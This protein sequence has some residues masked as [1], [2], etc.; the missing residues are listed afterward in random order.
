MSFF[1]DLL[2]FES[3]SSSTQAQPSNPLPSG[4]ANPGINACWLAS[5]LQMIANTPTLAASV[6]RSEHKATGAFIQRLRTQQNTT[7]GDIVSV[8]Q[9][10]SKATSL[11]EDNGNQQD[12]A[13]AL[14]AIL[15]M[16]GIRVQATVVR[17]TQPLDPSSERSI[18]IRVKNPNN[19]DTVKTIFIMNFPEREIPSEIKTLLADLMIDEKALPSMLEIRK[20]DNGGTELRIHGNT[21]IQKEGKWFQ[22]IEGQSI[23]IEI[24]QIRTTLENAAFE[25]LLA[26][27]LQNFVHLEDQEGN[28]KVLRLEIEADIRNVL[29]E[30]IDANTPLPSGLILKE[31]DDG[32]HLTIGNETYTKMAGSWYDQK[33]QEIP[34]ATLQAALEKARKNET[35]MASSSQKV[36]GVW[37]IERFEFQKSP[38]ELYLQA[39]RFQF[40]SGETRKIE[41]PIAMPHRFNLPG[42]PGSP[43]Y[44]CDSFIYHVG[45]SLDAGH[46]ISYFKRE[47]KW[48]CADDAIV[49]PVSDEAAHQMMRTSYLFHYAR[50]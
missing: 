10:L 27:S 15:N 7:L 17:D 18:G 29:G 1:L 20:L 19:D 14:G 32:F 22:V 43:T 47:G 48:Y 35:A 46:Y 12:A 21:F 26:S 9:E 38:Q 44:D 31:F 16:T 4:I 33:G 23:E 5:V 34:S 25:E 49:K 8:R 36:S 41:T 37:R 6:E 2:G 28:C 50:I 3:S 11:I 45:P 40:K 13:Q 30:L 42:L 39:G 24:A